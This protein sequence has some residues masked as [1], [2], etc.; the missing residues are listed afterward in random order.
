M[1]KRLIISLALSFLVLYSWSALTYNPQKKDATT[2]LV[3]VDESPVSPLDEPITIPTAEPSTLGAN[4]EPIVEEITSKSLETIES[5][6]FTATFSDIGGNIDNVTIKDFNQPFPLN[7]IISL[8]AYAN[9]KFTINQKTSTSI[10][11]TYDNT[12]LRITKSFEISPDDYLI[13]ANI[14]VE[15]KTNMS[16]RIN[17]QIKTFDVDTSNLDPKSGALN[18]EKSLF[19]YVLYSDDDIHRRNNAYEFKEKKDNQKFSGKANWLAFRDRYFAFIVKP[20][21]ET[22]RFYSKV[23]GD[24]VLELGL[25]A[26]AVELAPYSEVKY[27]HTIFAGPE[28]LSLLESYN[29]GFAKI[30]KFY[31]FTL[32]DAIAKIIYEIL[33]W[34]H[35]F[36]P[37][38]GLSIITISVIIYFSMYPLTLR[39]MQSMKK[40]QALQPKM[41]EIKEKHKN[42]PQKLQKETMELYKEHK[43]NPIGGCLPFIFQ[44]PVFIGLYQVLWRDVSFKGADFLWINDLSAPDRFYIMPFKLPF[45]GNEFNLLPILMMIIMFFQTKFQQKNMA[46]SADPAQKAQQKM[47]STIMPVFLCFIFYKFASGLT[48][49]FTMFYLFSAGTQFFIAQ[50]PKEA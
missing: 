41:A 36:I 43:I 4:V 15:N 21:Y 13:T 7:D 20:N 2:T 49:Y 44:M 38:W 8:P 9:K 10:S 40:I 18:R 19:E 16:K 1:E 17:L 3:D 50:K 14:F 39:G 29:L 46:V 33:H 37:N 34:I 26:P 32:F 47:M 11:Y 12:D 6:H 23:K 35:K 31:R 25:E 22:E 48:L 42:N 5:Q 45:F 30:K 28:K 27:S 24:N